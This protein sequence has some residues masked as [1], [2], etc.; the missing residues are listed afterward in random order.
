MKNLLTLFFLFLSLHLFASNKLILERSSLS[1]KASDFKQNCAQATFQTDLDINNVRATLLVGGDMWWNGNQGRYIVPK[2]AEG[3]AEVSSIF[4]G[5]VWMGGVDGFGNIKI[6]AQTYG[7]SAGLSDYW[8]GPISENGQGDAETCANWDR[9]FTVKGEDIDLHIQQF[10]E[11]REN[12]IPYDN[13]LIPQAVKEWPGLGSELFFD[14]VGFELPIAHQGL[15]PFWDEN[16]DGVYTPQFG[17]YPILEQRGCPSPDY[18]DQM[19]FWIF[20]DVGNVHTESGADPLQMEIQAQ[21]FAFKTNDQM[22]DMTFTRYKLVSRLNESLEGAYFGIWLDPDLGC[23]TDDFIGCD[24]TRN[25]MYVYNKDAVDG[26]DG[27]NCFG[28]VPTYGDKVPYFGVDFFR[29][30][31]GPKVFGSNGELIDPEVGQ[32]ADTLIELGMSSFV[33]FHNTIANNAVMTFPN[34]ATEYYNYLSGRWRNGDPLTYG[35]SGFGGTET[36]RFA[37]P[38]EPN[39]PNAWSMCSVGLP[40]ERNT[41]L[42]AT[43]PWRLD[44]GQ[45]NELIIGIPWVPDVAYPCPDMGRL[46]RADDLAQSY[47]DNCFSIA[48]GPDAPDID[49]TPLDKKLEAVLSNNEITSNNADESY[50][51]LGS[52][53][54][55]GFTQQEQLYNFEGYIV[56]QLKDTSVTVKEFND[57]EKARIVFQ[58]DRN[59]NASDLYNWT[60][61]ENPNAGTFDNPLTLVPELK[62][63]GANEGIRNTFEIT[64]DIF[65]GEPL[66]NYETYYYSAIAYAFNEYEAFDPITE[67]GQMTTYIEGRRNVQIYRVTPRGITDQKEIKIFPNPFSSTTSNMVRI[68]NLPP[69]AQISVYATDG[70]L[71]NRFEVGENLQSIEFPAFEWTPSSSSGTPLSSGIYFIHI[72]AE[73]IEERVL[74]WVSM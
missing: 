63:E 29:G 11:A 37:F 36:T 59:N 38:G 54:D 10:K 20:N 60:Y 48:D 30:P 69:D 46:F 50:W 33:Y 58:S 22:N 55:G 23:G 67:R 5:G 9:I 68:A 52:F 73:G 65:T 35:G 61:V 32:S 3:E 45:V 2:V 39:N 66:I 16:A 72:Q 27:S 49:W 1:N 57:S 26:D 40:D 53:L 7:T 19:S 42:Q 6:A 28:V 31:L 41:S 13:S 18:A 62:I 44:P 24:T 8:P 71:V 51:G 21:A 56:Y 64:E 17:D 4:V 14:A 74:K 34:T 70:K 15:A 25:L 47:F 12:D 43:G